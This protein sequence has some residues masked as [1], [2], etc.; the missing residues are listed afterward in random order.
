MNNIKER[1]RSVVAAQFLLEVASVKDSDSFFGDLGACS[2]DR[3]ELVMALEDEFSL[4]FPEE[5]MYGIGTVQEA[6][7]YVTSHV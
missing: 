7:D 5:V 4:E 3:V 1:V 6:I 2:L